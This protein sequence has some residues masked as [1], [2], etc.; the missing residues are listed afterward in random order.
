MLAL[1]SLNGYVRQRWDYTKRIS[2]HRFRS[3]AI[4]IRVISCVWNPQRNPGSFVERLLFLLSVPPVI[5]TAIAV[6]A[7]DRHFIAF[8]AKFDNKICMFS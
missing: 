5:G 8:A 3:P 2:F 7:S 6:M 4:C 1:Q